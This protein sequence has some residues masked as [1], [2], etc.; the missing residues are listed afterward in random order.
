MFAIRGDLRKLLL[1]K[2]KHGDGVQLL[3]DGHGKCAEQA[4]LQ[5]FPEQF[6]FK[7]L[8]FDVPRTLLFLCE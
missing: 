7:H 2:R 5:R 4:G 8:V 6:P 3:E 1:P